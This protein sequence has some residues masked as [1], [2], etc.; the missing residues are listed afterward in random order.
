LRQYPGR[1]PAAALLER[2]GARL[3]FLEDVSD[4]DPRDAGL[5]RRR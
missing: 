1:Y 3:T 4:N 5:V 2:A